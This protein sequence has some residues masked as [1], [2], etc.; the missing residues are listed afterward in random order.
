MGNR[1]RLRTDRRGPERDSQ[2][3]VGFRV[4]GLGRRRRAAGFGQRRRLHR[5]GKTPRSPS[6]SR[7]K[8]NFPPSGAAGSPVGAPA[9]AEGGEALRRHPERAN[10]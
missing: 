2:R 1:D 4:S 9:R 7:L 5:A 6:E 3:R 10:A 8:V